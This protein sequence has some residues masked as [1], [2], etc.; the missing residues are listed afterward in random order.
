MHALSCLKWCFIEL[1]S[2]WISSGDHNQ[3]VPT[4][5][6]FGPSSGKT[7]CQNL[8]LSLNSSLTVI[9]RSLFDILKNTVWSTFYHSFCGAR[10]QDGLTGSS[11]QRVTGWGQNV[12]QAVFSTGD[13]PEENL[14]PS[15]LGTLWPNL[16]P[17]YCRIEN[18]SLLL[19]PGGCPGLPQA[20][21]R[22]LHMA[23]S[24]GSM[25]Y[26]SLFFK[27]TRRVRTSF[28]ARLSLT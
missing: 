19:S 15:S 6:W 23:P 5:E 20:A 26:G 14:L 18:F 7:M 2:P 8:F 13:S 9:Q 3:I 25:Q 27:V 21:P 16:F 1:I 24:I 12:G 22:P 10:I 11:A 28:L 4:T 17:F